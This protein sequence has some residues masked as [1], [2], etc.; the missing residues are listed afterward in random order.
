MSENEIMKAVLL[1]VGRLANIRIFR[2]NVGTG[3]QGQAVRQW[4]EAGHRY[5]LLKDPRPLHAGLCVGSADLIGWRQVE[6][7]PEMVGQKI[8]VFTAIECKT[9]KGKATAEQVNFLRHVAQFGGN[10]IIAT[11][12]AD[13]LAKIEGNTI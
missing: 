8:A 12:A 13:A 6:I 3:W 1:A 4:Q 11:S 5:L 2:N 10:A 9:P 7:T